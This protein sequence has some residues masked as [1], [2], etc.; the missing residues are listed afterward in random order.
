MNLQTLRINRVGKSVYVN[1]LQGDKPNRVGN[2]RLWEVI[3][4]FDEGDYIHVPGQYPDVWKPAIDCTD[5]EIMTA[6]DQE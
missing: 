1:T 6:L 5:K 3:A 2:R 4:K